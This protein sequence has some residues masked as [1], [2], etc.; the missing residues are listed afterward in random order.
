MSR[1]MLSDI[2]IVDPLQRAPVHL[3]S[4]TWDT[5]GATGTTIAAAIAQFEGGRPRFDQLPC[6]ILQHA[7]PLAAAIDAEGHCAPVGGLGEEWRDVTKGYKRGN[8]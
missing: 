8:N 2:T 6:D 5:P 4:C 7:M 1:L 3:W